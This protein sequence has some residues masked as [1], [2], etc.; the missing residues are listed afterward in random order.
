MK[1]VL[2]SPAAIRNA[3]REKQKRDRAAAPVLSARYPQLATLQLEFDFSDQG[4]FLPSPQVVI[5]HPPARA[6]FR[7]ACPYNDCNGE[8]DLTAPVNEMISSNAHNA[9]GE[10]RCAGKRHGEAPCTLNLEYSISAQRN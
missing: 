7:F 2:N 9:E 4:D 8:F 6:Y 3:A 1:L 10:Q 5:F